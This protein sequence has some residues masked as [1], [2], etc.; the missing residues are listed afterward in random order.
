MKFKISIIYHPEDSVLN[1]YSKCAHV[2]TYW[3]CYILGD[4]NYISYINYISN[5]IFYELKEPKYQVVV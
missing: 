3:I 4:I 1:I 2:L 5:R